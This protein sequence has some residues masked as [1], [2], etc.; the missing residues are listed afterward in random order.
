MIKL[1]GKDKDNIKL[2]NHPLTNI[3]TSKHEKRRRQ[4]QNNE[5]TF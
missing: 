2:E 5:N 3:K 1:T 4:M